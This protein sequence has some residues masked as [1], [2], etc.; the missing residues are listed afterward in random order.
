MLYYFVP[1][2]Q[3]RGGLCFA[4][5]GGLAVRLSR[6]LDGWRGSSPAQPTDPMQPFAPD[7]DQMALIRAKTR[8]FNHH[9]PPDEL[10]ALCEQRIQ[11][12]FKALEELREE[13]LA[14]QAKEARR[15]AR[16]RGP[17]RRAAASPQ[18]QPDQ[19]LDH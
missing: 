1:W 6:I 2:T 4:Q 12:Y 14:E 19:H 17:R 18:R 9:L 10:D 8:R 11:D 15:R 16:T 7:E 13:W 5:R 3:R